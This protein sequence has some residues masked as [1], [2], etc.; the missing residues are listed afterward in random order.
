M[1]W[2]PNTRDFEAL[3][4]RW[5]MKL[6]ISGN[7]I[8]TL[9]SMLMVQKPT[10]RASF[11]M[12]GMS[13]MAIR[14]RPSASDTMPSAPGTNWRLNSSRPASMRCRPLACNSW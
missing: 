13:A 5:G 11:C 12:I 14:N 9:I 3:P 7:T 8:I 1:G 4:P 2:R 6:I 10:N